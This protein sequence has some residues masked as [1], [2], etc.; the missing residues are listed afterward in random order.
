MGFKS[1]VPAP[2]QTPIEESGGM[3]VVWSQWFNQRDQALASGDFQLPQPY[4]YLIHVV[5]AEGI[6]IYSQKLL[7]LKNNQIEF[8]IIAVSET[9]SPLPS[10]AQLVGFF[11]R[12]EAD[13]GGV[14]NSDYGTV[15]GCALEAMNGTLNHGSS[16]SVTLV[17]L[18]TACNQYYDNNVAPV[19]GVN[20]VFRNRPDGVATP[21][22]GIG[23]NKYGNNSRAIMISSDGRSPLGEACGWSSGIFFDA[24]SMDEPSPG[25]S[26]V[27]IDMHYIDSSRMNLGLWL[28]DYQKIVF[29]TDPTT[30]ELKYDPSIN[31]WGLSNNGSGRF[32]VGTNN[33]KLFTFGPT[34]A[35]GALPGSAAGYMRVYVDGYGTVSVPFF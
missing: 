25:F 9:S 19:A 16:T 3:T 20:S 1:L 33:G 2:Q 32:G 23:A 8:N 13:I 6:G 17:G 5:G 12:G 27:G 35:G 15:W 30:C 22:N 14:S 34:N 4:P 18:E 24:N 29:S 21:F 11:G 28:G 10:G 7:A 26:A 31:T